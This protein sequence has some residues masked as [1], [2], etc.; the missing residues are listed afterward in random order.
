MRMDLTAFREKIRVF[1]VVE[2]VIFLLGTILITNM[3]PYWCQQL[4][5]VLFCMLIFSALVYYFGV[6]RV[7]Y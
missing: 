5:G 2:L 3:H 1:L 7:Q 4:V 6:S